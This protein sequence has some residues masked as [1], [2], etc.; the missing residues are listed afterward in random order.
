MEAFRVGMR[1]LWRG[2]V[3]C[4]IAG[5]TGMLHLF[6]QIQQSG[7]PA[8][9]V[10]VVVVWG[11]TVYLAACVPWIQRYAVT[12][13]A[14]IS[15]PSFN[16]HAA[17]LFR[18]WANRR[19]QVWTGVAY[20]LIVAT[21]AFVITDSCTLPFR[22][23]L[24]IFLSVVNYATGVA[25]LL[26]AS[27][28][29]FAYRAP[30]Y[31]RSV[32][33]LENETVH[34]VLGITRR[35]ALVASIYSSACISS[36]LF[37][38][39]PFQHLVGVYAIFCG[40]CILVLVGGPAWSI[41]VQRS[42]AK[43]SSTTEIDRAIHDT[44]ARILGQDEVGI[45]AERLDALF[46]MRDRAGRVTVWPFRL[47]ALATSLQVVVISSAPIVVQFLLTRWSTAG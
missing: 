46:V 21:G 22:I 6:L 3:L 38:A 37:S 26:T 23:T 19:A 14:A 9:T 40:G 12:V 47:G 35:I 41:S 28:L 10:F 11:A 32:W 24:A 13:A 34:G 15:N 20:G 33:L 39:I 27:A 30:Q 31:I 1:H 42:S 17:A 43:I 29:L 16:A 25:L 2:G 36:I 45:L 4:A 44:C 5:I 18:R 7:N 8:D